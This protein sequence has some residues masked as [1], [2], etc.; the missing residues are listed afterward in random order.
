MLLS[1]TRARTIAAAVMMLFAVQV[2][3]ARQDNAVEVKTPKDVKQI[4]QKR[5][6]LNWARKS[7]RVKSTNSQMFGRQLLIITRIK[8]TK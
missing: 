3:A 6:W 5:N 1:P 7:P 8:L 4:I 2:S